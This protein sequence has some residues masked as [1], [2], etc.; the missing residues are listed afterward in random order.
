MLATLVQAYTLLSP[1]TLGQ[2]YT[3][4]SPPL[5]MQRPRAVAPVCVAAPPQATIP[6]SLHQWLES[7]GVST[8]KVHGQQLPGFG[9]SL[10]AGKHGVSAGD[11]LLTVPA[12][13]HMTPTS[14]AETPV[15]KAV[16]GILDDDSALLALGLLQEG[17]RGPEE[18][19]CWPYWE[20]LPT[21][22]DMLV[23]LL[24]SDEERSRLLAGSHLEDVVISL[25]T[26]LRSQWSLLESS[27]FPK[28][29]EL[30]PPEVFRF[31]GYLWAHAVVLTRALPFGDSLSLI[32]FLDLANH[33][34]GATNMCSIA[35]CKK[36]G[37]V[38]AVSEAWQLEELGGEAAAVITASADLAP[39]EQVFIDYG[40][41]GWRSSWEMLCAHHR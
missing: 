31:E 25:L 8:S 29:P 19:K 6:E 15:G 37:G 7:K 38:Q 33:V 3:L 35:M 40:E 1:P 32:P 5:H 11:T 23:P 20:L 2:A 12:S 4:I 39:G 30:F 34:A 16:E 24:W 10:V 18:S 14:V 28:Q 41:A 9:L 26:E 17:A 22:E 27:V 21:S 13:M 36:D